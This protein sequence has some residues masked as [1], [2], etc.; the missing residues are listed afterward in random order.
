MKIFLLLKA[1]HYLRPFVGTVEQ[2][3]ERGHQIRIA[4][5]TSAAKGGEQYEELFRPHPGVTFTT[6]SGT[7]SI[8]RRE[9]AI[10]RRTWN[11]LR[12]LE[13]PYRGAGKLRARAL[14][15]LLRMIKTDAGQ[16]HATGGEHLG[17]T[18]S[19]KELERVKGVLDYVESLIPGDPECEEALA[20][21][22]PDVLLVSPLVD[23]N[24]ST[25]ADFVK[26]ATAQGVPVGL[27][28]YSWDNLSTKGGLHTMPDRVFVWNERQKT[29]AL[30]LHR[31]PRDRV[32][33]TGAPRFDPFL[34]CESRVDHADFCAALGFKRTTPILMYLCSSAFV[35]GD[36]LPF[37]ERWIREVR[38]AASDVVR[39]CNIVVRPHPDVPLVS[40]DVPAV[41]PDWD[42]AELSAAVRRPFADDGAV[43]LSTTS[44]SP[45]GLFESIWHSRAVIGLNTSAEIE[46]G[47]VGRPVLS[48]LAG[49]AADGQETSLHFH[50]LLKSHHGFVDVAAS[51]DEHVAQLEQA[52]L[53]GKS[54]GRRARRAALRFVRPLGAEIPVARVLADAI[55]REFSPTGSN[56]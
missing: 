16:T 46:A 15:K 40:V 19:P 9:V 38:N 20:A 18:L 23:L 4:W 52:V 36:E 32:V 47:L 30:K 8:H 7:R 22:A 39:G 31:V 24:S 27:L 1:P 6:V 28:V 11:Y 33:I 13:E 49:G 26:A 53:H 41:K 21:F 44:V 51:W 17:M 48:I 55:E 54:L 5:F 45:Q 14:D 56:A 10:I 34:A 42:R 12:Y 25:Q 2:L 3:A 43:L 50:Y 29:E 35:S 37:V